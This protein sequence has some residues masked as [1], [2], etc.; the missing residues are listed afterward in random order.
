MI[1]LMAIFASLITAGNFDETIQ[2]QV[3]IGFLVLTP[4]STVPF[5]QESFACAGRR[6]SV[7][8]FALP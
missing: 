8:F 6:F 3:A 2:R 7:S 1:V 4:L 5:R